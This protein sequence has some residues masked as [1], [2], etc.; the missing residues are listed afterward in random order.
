[1][2][3]QR[4]FTEVRVFVD[5]GERSPAVGDVVAAP[6]AHLGDRR[7]DEVAGFD[8]AAIRLDLLEV[9]PRR[10]GELLGEVLDE[11]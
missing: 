8:E 5:T 2:L 9:R 11:P 6:V 10:L 1:M 4:R 3:W 7:G